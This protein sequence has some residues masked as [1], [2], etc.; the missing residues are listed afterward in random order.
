LGLGGAC[1]QGKQG[2]KQE[3]N[4]NVSH[5]NAPQYGWIRR[6]RLSAIQCNPSTNSK[7]KL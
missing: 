1:A 7:L 4:Q 5:G 2:C 3:S 6:R